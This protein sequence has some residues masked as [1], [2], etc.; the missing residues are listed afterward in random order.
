MQITNQPGCPNGRL[1]MKRNEGHGFDE[2]KER[3]WWMGPWCGHQNWQEWR[4]VW[5]LQKESTH[6]MIFLLNMLND[7][8]VN[9][10][11]EGGVA[12]RCQQ[13]FPTLEIKVLVEH[14]ASLSLRI[15]KESNH[16]RRWMEAGVTKCVEKCKYAKRKELREVWGHKHGSRRTRLPDG[17]GCQW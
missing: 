17:S 1:K 5:S 7:Q 8:D 15:R 9:R 4:Q 14:P 6:V 12:K 3:W 13:S 11:E 2:I 10:W 16:F